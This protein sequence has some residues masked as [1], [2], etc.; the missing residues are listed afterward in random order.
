[1]L[2]DLGKNDLNC[3]LTTPISN[4]LLKIKKELTY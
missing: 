2:I 3:G 1:M 4:F